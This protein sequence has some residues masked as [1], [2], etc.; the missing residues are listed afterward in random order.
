LTIHIAIIDH[1]TAAS[2]IAGHDWYPDD[3]HV[4]VVRTVVDKN[5]YAYSLRSEGNE[6]DWL[7]LVKFPPEFASGKQ[8]FIRTWPKMPRKI[9]LFLSQKRFYCYQIRASSPSGIVMVFT[10]HKG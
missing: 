10:M 1:I 2:E 4:M 9:C 3:E 5:N 7:V 6:R 8:L